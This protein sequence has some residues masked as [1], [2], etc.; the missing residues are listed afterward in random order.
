MLLHRE[1]PSKFR[2]KRFVSLKI[3]SLHCFRKLLDPD[4]ITPQKLNPPCDEIKTPKWGLPGGGG[5][6]F[7]AVSAMTS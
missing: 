2:V 1:V 7:K 3:V 5:G 4:V 6:Y